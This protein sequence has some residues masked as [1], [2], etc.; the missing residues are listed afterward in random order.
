MPG[1]ENYV[2]QIRKATYGRDVREAIANGIEEC[3]SIAQT[4]ADTVNSIVVEDES[5]LVLSKIE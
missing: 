2:E 5:G 3:A 1:I 4:A